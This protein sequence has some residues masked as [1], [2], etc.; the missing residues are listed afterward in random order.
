VAPHVARMLVG[1]DQRF[2]MPMSALCGAALLSCASVA[3][4]SIVPG[5]LF[6]IGIV[7]AMIGVPFFV[8]LVLGVRRSYW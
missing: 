6:P 7:T 8:W 1:E 4:K 3:S 2:L 5:A